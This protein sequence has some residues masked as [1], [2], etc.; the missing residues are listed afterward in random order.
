MLIAC[1]PWLG[2]VRS[3]SARYLCR[4]SGLKRETPYEAAFHVSGWSDWGSPGNKKASGRILEARTAWQCKHSAS[5]RL[6]AAKRRKIGKEESA[7]RRAVPQMGLHASV[8]GTDIDR[9]YAHARYMRA[10]SS[11]VKDL[12]PAA[13][14]EKAPFAL[15]ACRGSPGTLLPAAASAHTAPPAPRERAVTP[16]SPKAFKAPSA[17]QSVPGAGPWDGNLCR[18]AAATCCSRCTRCRSAGRWFCVW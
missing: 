3:R 9:C 1:R 12:S 8:K 7:Q 11:S 13:W 10:T 6:P 18:C 17:P 16:V 4:R 2:S 14:F 15:R 5:R